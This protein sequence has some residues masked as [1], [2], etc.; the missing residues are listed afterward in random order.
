AA[1]VDHSL[2]GVVSGIDVTFN[3]TWRVGLAG[4]YSHSTFKSPDIGASGASEN[5]HIALYGGG[6]LGA[7]GLRGGVSY[8]WHDVSTSRGV[9]VGNL[10]GGVRGEYTASTTQVFGEIGH[11][12]ALGRSAIE[13]FVNLAYVHVD[14]GTIREHGVAAMTGSS[15]LDTT[16]TTLGVRGSVA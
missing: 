1:S 4:G 11:T 6:Q 9:V 5:Y 14:G 15:K 12:I 16:Y 7:W 2:G 8:S 3:G 10:S 13:P